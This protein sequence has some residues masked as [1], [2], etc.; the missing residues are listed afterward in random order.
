MFI[1][2]FL[3][4]RERERDRTQASRLGAAKEGDRDSQAGS[5][6]SMWAQC[7]AQSHKPWVH[8]EQKSRVRCLTNWAPQAPPK[9]AK[10]IESH[11]TKEDT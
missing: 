11:F 4:K 10:K 9:I 2:L 3:R 6:L 5:T 7:G 1:Y 8:N